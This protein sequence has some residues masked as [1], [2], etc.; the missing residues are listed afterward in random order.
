MNDFKTAAIVSSI[1]ADSGLSQ[2]KF[3]QM[4]GVSRPSVS[5]WEKGTYKPEHE[6]AVKMLKVFKVADDIATLLLLSLS[7]DNDITLD[8]VKETLPNYELVCLKPKPKET[9]K[10]PQ[11]LL[12]NI[13]NG[14]FD[15]VISGEITIREG[16]DPEVMAKHLYRKIFGA[17]SLPTNNSDNLHLAEQG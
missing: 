14:L 10:D 1:R 13:T 16:G 7:D 9:V 11:A 3:A 17:E 4:I 6:N 8:K 15:L 5:Q 12:L 2:S